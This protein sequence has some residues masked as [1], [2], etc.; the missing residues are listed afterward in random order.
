M[1]A[2]RDGLRSCRSFVT[3]VTLPAGVVDQLPDPARYGALLG[4]SG[5]GH[6]SPPSSYG[7]VPFTAQFTW[8]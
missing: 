6:P 7:Q 8:S 5:H 4:G 2:F 1:G 3:L